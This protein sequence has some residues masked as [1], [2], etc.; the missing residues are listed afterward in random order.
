[1]LNEEKI[2]TRFLDDAQGISGFFQ[3]VWFENL[4]GAKGLFL[5]NIGVI[6]AKLSMEKLKL[7]GNLINFIDPEMDPDEILRI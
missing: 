4:L 7:L 2:D 3:K 1:M 5:E 6:L